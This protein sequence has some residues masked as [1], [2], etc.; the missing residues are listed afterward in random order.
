MTF[1]HYQYVK[2]SQ[3]GHPDALSWGD[4]TLR[5]LFTIGIFFSQENYERHT[6]VLNFK[7]QL[8]M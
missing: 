4:E 1:L 2:Y 5:A 6:V 3:E 7:P 8:S